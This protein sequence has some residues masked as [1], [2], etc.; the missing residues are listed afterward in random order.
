[1]DSFTWGIFFFL[2][3]KKDFYGTGLTKKCIIWRAFHLLLFV[4]GFVEGRDDGGPG[5]ESVRCDG[6]DV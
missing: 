5:Y 4:V 3:R 1:V 2:V 6:Q